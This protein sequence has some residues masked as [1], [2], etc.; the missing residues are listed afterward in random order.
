MPNQLSSR[1]H[2]KTAAERSF[3]VVS[4][5]PGAAPAT[6]AAHAYARLGDAL[7]EN[8]LQVVHERVFASLGAQAEI[9]T[10]RRQ[11]FEARGIAA[12]GP[13]TFLQ[14]QPIRG[15]GFA[16]VILHAV[17]ADCGRVRILADA[18]VPCGRSWQIDGVRYFVLQNVQGL[19]PDEGGDNR[20]A[21]QARRAIERAS[22][23]LTQHGSG[24]RETARTW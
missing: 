24:Y 21:S 18:G 14:G 4:A 15:D 2:V 10:A 23:I 16:G 3:L 19:V 7:A 22:R 20:P 13:L 6:A 1:L 5:P 8:G 12:D 17:P 9:Q 11:A